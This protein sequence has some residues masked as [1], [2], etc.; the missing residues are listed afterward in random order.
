[1]FKKSLQILLILLLLPFNA[2]GYSKSLVLGGEN[3]GIEVSLNGVIVVGTY[4]VDE[5]NPGVDAGLKTG[6]I[7]TK[8][9]NK[10][11]LTIEEMISNMNSD[12]IQITFKRK[13]K[14]MKT[15]LKPVIKDGVIKTGLYVKDSIS[16]IGTLSFIDPETKLYGAL[17]H[18]ITSKNTGELLEIKNGQIFKSTVTSIERSENGVPGAK[19]AS[20]SDEVLGNILK[21]TTSGI[22][23]TYTGDIDL[24]NQYK[25]A[26]INDIKLGRAKIKTVIEGNTIKEYDI[27][28][29]KINN[30][31]SNKNIL[32][33]ITDTELINKTGGVVQG[34]SGSP[35]IQEDYII[36]VVNY[37]IVDS[38]NKGYGILINSM[39]EEMEKVN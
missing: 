3:I 26:T 11:I 4:L 15:E 12:N 5:K 24:N 31:E 28:I 35:I 39:L 21:N 23:G 14:T 17:G 10:E 2:L 9:N 25:V 13:N 29:L 7:I 22:Y 33:E 20:F 8:V 19:N 16:G 38:P 32:F 34:M 1:M 37:V 30:D 36:G 6:D 18:E 27:N